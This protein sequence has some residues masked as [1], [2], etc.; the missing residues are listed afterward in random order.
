MSPAAGEAWLI[1]GIPGAGK[2]MVARNLSLRF[3]RAAHIEGDRLGEWITSGRVDPGQPPQQESERQ[4]RLNVISA[5][6]PAHTRGLDLF[7]SSTTL[8]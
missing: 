2:S 6:W 3:A 4:I 7:R 1:T 5:S 8:L